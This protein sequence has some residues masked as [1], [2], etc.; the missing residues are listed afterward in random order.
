MLFKL[1][2]IQ[3]SGHY[4]MWSELCGNAVNCELC[5]C[6]QKSIQSIMRIENTMNA[7][8][9]LQENFSYKYVWNEFSHHTHY[10][11]KEFLA[12][13]HN[14]N[15]YSIQFEKALFL[16]HVFL[17]RWQLMFVSMQI[18]SIREKMKKTNKMNDLFKDFP[19]AHV[20]GNAYV[21][22]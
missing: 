17:F 13:S 18:W 20:Y 10:V 3:A 5:R 9:N 11:H 2:G 6:D 21:L 7:F 8:S 22:H 1:Q 14:A 12:S 16:V 4:I 19:C 15:V